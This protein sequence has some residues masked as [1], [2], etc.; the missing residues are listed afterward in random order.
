MTRLEAAKQLRKALQMF[1]ETLEDEK[2]IEVVAVFPTWYID[3][4]YNLGDRIQYQDELYKC[5]VTH[6]SQENWAPNI[7]PSLWA[8]V[9]PGQNGEIGEWTQ[10]DSTNPYMTGDKVL[11]GGEKWISTVDNNI[12]APD[13]YGWQR[14]D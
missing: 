3:R 6:T 4:S 5:L 7:A 13:V 9:L 11:F 10:P 2:A 12:W 1:V 14:I 8:K